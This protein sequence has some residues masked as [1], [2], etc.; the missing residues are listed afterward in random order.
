MEWVI[1]VPRILRQDDSIFVLNCLVFFMIG[2]L[3]LMKSNSDNPSSANQK[4][5]KET[6]QL[7]E[8]VTHF[9]FSDIVFS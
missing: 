7:L 1:H 6:R 9:V 2:L 3:K 4:N 5:M 8:E